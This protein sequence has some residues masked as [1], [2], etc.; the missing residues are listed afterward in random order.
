[1][2]KLFVIILSLF[3][4]F[5]NL[6]QAQSSVDKV[7]YEIEYSSNALN[8]P[9]K[10]VKSED[11]KVL[12]IGDSISRFYSFWEDNIE[13]KRDSLRKKGFTA[14][15]IR[16]ATGGMRR[17]YDFSNVYKNYPL[18]G[19]ITIVDN[20]AKFFIYEDN[21]LSPKWEIKNENKTI[22][23][24]KCQKAETNYRGRNWIVW[25]T[26]EIP[27]SD[28]PWKLYGLPGL[29]LQA[30]DK[31]DEFNFICVGIRNVTD[32]NDSLIFDKKNG[33]KTTR[34]EYLK[35]LSDFFLEPD[36]TMSKIMGVEIKNMSPTKIERSYNPIEF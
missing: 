26:P 1:M 5:N 25:F 18:K 24:Y 12:Q 28:G 7:K 33:I 16:G 10:G 32:V 2:K 34:I 21:V 29:I 22:L 8:I 17:S 15:Q 14:E 30:E 31:K 9:H 36:K 19:K 27:I 3:F 6:L 11:I 35:L 23:G 20:I 4:S 13:K